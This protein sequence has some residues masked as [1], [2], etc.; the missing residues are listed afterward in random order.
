MRYLFVL[1]LLAGCAAAEPGNTC[2]SEGQ[3]VGDMIQ[4]HSSGKVGTV[5]KIYGPA[6]KCPYLTNPIAADVRY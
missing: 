2:L 5:V 3:K 6:K 1:L 4:N